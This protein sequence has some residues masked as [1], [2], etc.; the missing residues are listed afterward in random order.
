VPAIQAT[1]LVDS[2]HH[3]KTALYDSAS[4]FRCIAT[5]IGTPSNVCLEERNDGN[6][7]FKM[8]SAT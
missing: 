1:I 2:A 5:E 3:L 4:D 7:H 6:I 8:F